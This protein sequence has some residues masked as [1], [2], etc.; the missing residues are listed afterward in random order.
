M[1]FE[2]KTVWFDEYMVTANHVHL[3]VVDDGDFR[4]TKTVDRKLEEAYSRALIGAAARQRA[5]HALHPT[6]ENACAF[7][8]PSLRSA[9]G[10]CRR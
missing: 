2:G 4:F 10:G 6:A 7:A 3:L 5:N 1:F 8:V 9:A